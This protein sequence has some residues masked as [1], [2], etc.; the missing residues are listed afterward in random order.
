MIRLEKLGRLETII[1]EL[2]IDDARFSSAST[3][4]KHDH[5]KK[6]NKIFTS[7]VGKV[8]GSE[9]ED[10]AAFLLYHLK[11]MF[12]RRGYIS[13]CVD[14]FSTRHDYSTLSKEARKSRSKIYKAFDEL[15]AKMS[16]TLDQM[17][18]KK[19]LN[20]RFTEINR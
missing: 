8:V 5:W 14:S 4:A 3:R 6:E 7:F 18:Q 20:A 10:Q 16:G 19:F 13:A 17:T 12:P 2:K 15:L 9:I 1:G 11:N